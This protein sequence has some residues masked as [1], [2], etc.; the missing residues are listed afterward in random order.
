MN[1]GEILDSGE[2]VVWEAR[3]A[4]RCF[5]FRQWRQALFGAVFLLLCLVWLAWGG[6][7]ARAHDAPWAA[8][9][10]LPFVLLGV[11]LSVGR[12]VVARLEWNNVAFAITDRHLVVRRGLLR[13]VAQR[14]ALQEVTYFR[15]VLHAEEL[16]NLHVHA[17]DTRSLLLPC[18]EYPR[19]ATQLLEE[20]MGDRARPVVAE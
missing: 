19:K 3:P 4:P 5:V 18:I 8:W 1:W 7:V 13:P 10:P 20:A 15:L 14:L 6:A 11:Y 16:G 9:L 2:Q 17:G 12:L